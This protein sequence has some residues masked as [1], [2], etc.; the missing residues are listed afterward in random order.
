MCSALTSPDDLLCTCCHDAPIDGSNAVSANAFVTYE[1]KTIFGNVALWRGTSTAVHG[2]LLDLTS[3]RRATYGTGPDPV[4]S[5]W[6]VVLGFLASRRWG[7]LQQAALAASP[8]LMGFSDAGTAGSKGSNSP[9]AAGHRSDPAGMVR[10][11]FKAWFSCQVSSS[12]PRAQ[13]HGLRQADNL[14]DSR[15]GPLSLHQ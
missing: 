11:R 15:S 7:V 8:G 12:I 1:H 14:A 13:K 9:P 2:H 6:H 4:P 3:L 10:L 5:S